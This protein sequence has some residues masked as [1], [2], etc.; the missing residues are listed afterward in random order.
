M[1]KVDKNI[2]SKNWVHSHEEDTDKEMVFRPSTFNFPL[3]RGRSS[4]ELKADGTLIQSGIAPD[5]RLQNAT[6]SWKLNDDNSLAFYL[7]SKSVPVKSMKIHSADN[8][9][10][11][12]GKE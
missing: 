12:I 9:K 6:G 10:L 5:D 4:F 7:G 1:S 11:V 2:L 3:A 8:S